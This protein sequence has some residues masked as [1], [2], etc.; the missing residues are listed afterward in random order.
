MVSYWKTQW[1]G[2]AV[3]L[4][5]LVVGIVNLFKCDLLWCFAWCGMAFVWFIVTRLDYNNERIKVLEKKAEK[6]DALFD[7][8][9][10][11]YEANKIDREH[12]DIMNRKIIYALKYIEEELDK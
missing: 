9:D 1:F 12:M 4:A 6:Y 2:V 8:V 7:K 10:A 5:N 3:G 11:L